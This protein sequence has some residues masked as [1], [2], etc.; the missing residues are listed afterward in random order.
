M[1][2]KEQFVEDRNRFKSANNSKPTID[3]FSIEIRICIEAEHR[4]NDITS[5]EYIVNM[6][7]RI[8][9]DFKAHE[10]FIFVIC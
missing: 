4:R 10:N 1:F 8:F 5:S 6:Q 9:I 2:K 3:K 7:L